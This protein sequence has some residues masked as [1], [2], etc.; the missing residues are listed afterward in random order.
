MTAEPRFD[1]ADEEARYW[2]QKAS[3]MQDALRDAETGLQ[4]FME[5]SK[6]L[7]TE[8]EADIAQS[9]RR[10][11]D[12]LAANERLRGDADEWKVCAPA[13]YREWA[14]LTAGK[15]PTTVL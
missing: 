14:C 15:I 12:L 3:Q 2:R 8:L 6:E 1:S 9:N 10:I 11:D 13:E 4:D 7:E 5:S